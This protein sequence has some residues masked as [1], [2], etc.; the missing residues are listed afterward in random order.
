[1]PK[2][3]I[4]DK[5]ESMKQKDATQLAS[6]AHNLRRSYIQAGNSVDKPS[7]FDEFISTATRKYRA[8]VNNRHK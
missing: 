4:E 2:F 7:G 3:D 5:V 8:A 1:M 6:Y